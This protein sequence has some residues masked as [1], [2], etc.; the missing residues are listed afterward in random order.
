MAWIW[1]GELRD[2]Q[3]SAFCC[4]ILQSVMWPI[5]WASPSQAHAEGIG[6]WVC[7]AT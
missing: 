5:R 7:G 3:W 2:T 1:A 4:P 6:V